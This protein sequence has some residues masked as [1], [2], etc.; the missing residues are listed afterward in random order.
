VNAPRPIGWWARANLERVTHHDL[1]IIGSGSGNSIIDE[2]MAD[3][4]VGLVEAGT[5]GG[6]CLNVGCIPTKMFVFPADVARHAR[7]DAE[8]LG[9]HAHVDGVDWPA[10]RDR[11]FGRIDAI[12]AGGRRWRVEDNENVDV[13]ETH[14]RLTGPRSLVTAD[15][16]ELT[17][18]RLVIAAG[19]RATLPDVPG[20]RAAF[21]DPALP[22]HTS[23]TIMRMAELPRRL[24]IIGGGYVAAEFAHVFSSFGTEVVIAARGTTLMSAFDTDV[25]AR[26][27]A[28]AHGQ[29]DVRLEHDLRSVAARPDGVDVYGVNRATGEPVTLS[30]DAVLVATGRV[31]NTDGLDVAAAGFR[32]DA[33][34]FLLVDEFQRVLDADGPVDDVWALGDI[35]S[36]YLLKHVA[37]AEMRVVQ[38][39]LLNPS[40]LQPSDHRFVPSAVFSHPQ[41]ATVGLTEAEAV[42]QGRDFVSVIQPY[43]SI[44]YGWAMEED[45]DTGGFCKLLADR[46]TGLLIGAHIIGYQAAVLLQ[47]LVQAMSFGLPVKEM[48]RGQY[49]PHPALTELL[50]NALL[51]LP[52]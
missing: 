27:T 15:G 11:I 23:D 25:A 31:P 49:W 40:A 2:R 30:G 17:A 33:D 6:T 16:R 36:P 35:S 8:R 21:A 4:R 39:N 12:S 29:W 38:H 7:D 45:G 22:V 14:V 9:V 47:P 44:A 26:F 1:I 18:D 34:G 50:E 46:D 32:T 51:A 28:H 20:L 42:A 37:N 19:S 48:A 24:I 10:I 13:Y 41:V 5:F 43:A 3:W 52:L